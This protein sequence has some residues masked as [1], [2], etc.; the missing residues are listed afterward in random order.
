MEKCI[1]EI[2]QSGVYRTKNPLIITVIVRY[3]RL[4]NGC[5]IRLISNKLFL[6]NVK[7]IQNGNSNVI[8]AKTGEH[9]ILTIENNFGQYPVYNKHYNVEDLLESF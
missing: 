1:L 7:S 6:G 3:G 5:P 8:S 2:V 4:R 9:V